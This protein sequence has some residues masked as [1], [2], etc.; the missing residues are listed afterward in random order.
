[1]Y[2]LRDTAV[3]SKNLD[4]TFKSLTPI[5]IENASNSNLIRLFPSL[6]LT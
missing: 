2:F 5:E 1:M 4:P 3:T 6:S